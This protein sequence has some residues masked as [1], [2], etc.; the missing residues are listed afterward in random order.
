MED[1]CKSNEV[2]ASRRP[3]RWVMGWKL[4]E[5]A[6]RKRQESR[7]GEEL[8]GPRGMGYGRSGCNDVG[9]RRRWWRWF[10]PARIDSSMPGKETNPHAPFL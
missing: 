10:P 6:L 7:V 3:H 2:S 9:R 1:A 5:L 4:N 8:R